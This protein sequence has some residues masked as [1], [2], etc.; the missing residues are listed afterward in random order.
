MSRLDKNTVRL[1]EL[2][3]LWAIG[4]LGPKERTVLD[5][6]TPE[7]QSSYKRTGPWHDILAAELGFT[8]GLAAEVRQ[9]WQANSK[10]TVAGKRITP[11]EFA[12]MF[13]AENFSA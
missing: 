12:Q 9:I 4:E 1:L 5:K 7:L 13:V 6:V 8:P 11:R 2:Y 3:V 10:A